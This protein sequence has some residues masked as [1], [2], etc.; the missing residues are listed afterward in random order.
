MYTHTRTHTHT[1]G[2]YRKKVSEVSRVS[3]CQWRSVTKGGEAYGW[4]RRPAALGV[5]VVLTVL[6][7]PARNNGFIHFNF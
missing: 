7:A 6:L 2:P 1:Y 4:L 3:V 5:L